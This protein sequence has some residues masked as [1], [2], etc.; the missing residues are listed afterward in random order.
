MK[1]IDC[2][3][4]TGGKSGFTKIKE[5]LQERANELISGPSEHRAE[6]QVV[7]HLGKYLNNKFILLRNAPIPGLDFPIPI[8]LI[9]PPGIFVIAAT[10]IKGVYR[11]KD[12]T[13]AKMNEKDRQ[14]EPARPNL[15]QRTLQMKQALEDFLSTGAVKDA[16]LTAILVCT[17]TGVHV[18]SMR[19]AVRIVMTD[20]LGRFT[21]SLMQSA[22]LLNNIEIKELVDA[23]KG[24]LP[25][26]KEPVD[27]EIRDA[28]AF[29]DE[30][31]KETNTVRAPQIQPVLTPRLVSASKRFRLTTGQWIFVGVML[32]IEIILLMGIILLISSMT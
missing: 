28:F 9:G 5:Q 25:A 19:P 30:T 10:P 7:A 27:T 23:V 12:D 31:P 4:S 22:G 20:G 3:P 11:A 6:E 17:N 14:F 29:I 8:I 18:G 32:M 26:S 1:I 16:E 24:T 13:W 2:S 21:G 15:V